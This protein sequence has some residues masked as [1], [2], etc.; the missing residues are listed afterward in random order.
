MR[1]GIAGPP[2]PVSG[3]TLVN[4]ANHLVYARL[5]LGLQNRGDIA[6]VF[7]PGLRDQRAASLGISL[8]PH[9]DVAVDQLF[10]IVH[11]GLHQRGT[12]L[13]APPPISPLAGRNSI[14]WE[15]RKG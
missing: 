3:E 12:R 5:A 4:A 7:P 2:K 15:V 10:E 11:L 9:C 1:I 8:V 6:G 14:T 13:G